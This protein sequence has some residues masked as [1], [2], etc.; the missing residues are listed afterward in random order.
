MIVITGASGQ[1]GRLVI[2]E[3]LATIPA[4]QI[5]AAVRDPKKVEDLAEKGV[6]IRVADY[7]QANTLTSAFA[8]AK[9]VLLISSSE[10]GQRV[11]QHA[12]VINAAKQAKVELIAYTSILNAPTSPLPLAAEHKATEQL[13]AE[14]G[15]PFVLLRNGW[16]T[17]NYTASIPSALQYGVLIGS[18]G[19]GKIST[20]ARADYAAAAAKVLTRDN[21]AG[22]IYEL[23]GD[24]S[25]TLNEFAN[26]IT[27]K[28]GKPI[29]YQNLPVEAYNQALLDAGLPIPIAQLLSESDEGASKGGLYDDSK[30]LSQLINRPTVTLAL[31]VEAALTTLA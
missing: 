19:Q 4:N 6:Q 2:N 1:L 7:N 24:E 5:I 12:N 14:S 26:T 20:A 3:L 18:A 10:I 31:A 13:L 25:Y 28:V 16:Y 22:M 8:G 23:A 15:L 17:E 11:G 9:K 30:T 27:E 29:P 21:Q